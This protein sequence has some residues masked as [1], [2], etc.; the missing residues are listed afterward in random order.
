MNNKS[1]ATILATGALIS[2]PA[3]WGQTATVT[4][5]LP[6]A[7]AVPVLGGGLLLLLGLMLAVLGAFWLSRRPE[8]GRS[9]SVSF[10][11]LGTALVLASSGWLV[12]HVD[13]APA[14]K[15]FLLSENSSPVKIATFPA[16]LNNDLSVPV[17]LGSI[18]I[19]GCPGESL[20]SGT[21]APQLSLAAGNG[22]CSI[23]SICEESTPIS[24]EVCFSS[25]EFATEDPWVICDIDENEAWISADTG[26]EYNAPAICQALGFDAVGQQG[27]TC[28][29]VCGYCES[30]TSCESPGARTFDGG[31][32][33]PT[34]LSTT[35]QWTCVNVP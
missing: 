34:S 1:L 10:T 26:G 17:K 24:G 4:Y 7:A 35:V 19:S 15:S 18:N 2:A 33:D 8:I 3:V 25:N 20:L 21:C 29:N 32:G 11:V 9:L 14:I 13:A 12:S 16:E 31:G 28:G 22:S 23:D 5:S 30:G 6:P 27:G